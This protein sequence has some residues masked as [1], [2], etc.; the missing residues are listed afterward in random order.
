MFALLGRSLVAMVGAS[1]PAE[2]SSSGTSATAVEPGQGSDAATRYEKGQAAFVLGHYA[3]CVTHLEAAIEAAAH[4]HLSDARTLDIR[5][6]LA[7]CRI[8]LGG[9]DGNPAELRRSA[10]VL[11]G[12]V[13]DASEIG[14]R[15]DDVAFAKA[16]LGRIERLLAELTTP[17]CPDAPPPVIA[18]EDP[19]AARLREQ[20]RRAKGGAL[21]GSG[22]VLVVL[23][24]GLIGYGAAV[25]PQARRFGVEDQ[26]P[27][28]AY[29]AIGLG[30]GVA[31]AVVGI[32]GIVWGALTLSDRD[33]RA[34]RVALVRDGFAVS[35]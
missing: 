27:W 2:T 22:A 21:V 34:R 18:R 17:A 14:I 33:R 13:D 29:S 31:S 26:R 9:V 11:R 32:G 3:E 12:I 7:Q 8:E 16:E 20:R 15:E 23:G 10:T 1:A 35:F 24:G 6:A 25:L 30:F 5:I 28:R 4:E 19:A